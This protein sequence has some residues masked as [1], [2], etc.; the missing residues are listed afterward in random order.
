VGLVKTFFFDTYALI[1]LV[2]GSPNYLKYSDD[3]IITTQLNL[4]EFYY[5]LISEFSKE[6]AKTIYFKF[7]DCSKE[8]DDE[9]IFEAMEFRKKYNKR[10]LSYVDCIGY[11]FA[12]KN[13]IEFLTGDKEFEDLPGVEFVK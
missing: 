6:I 5:S 7:K 10:K 9:I 3:K 12:K 4:I 2:K 13:N 11:I 1:E 8:I